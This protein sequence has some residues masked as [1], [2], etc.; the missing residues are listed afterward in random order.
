VR[1]DVAED[2]GSPQ[3]HVQFSRGPES[4]LESSSHPLST[5]D[6]LDTN[7]D[8]P[9]RINCPHKRLP[10][11]SPIPIVVLGATDSLR[12]PSGKSYR[13]STRPALMSVALHAVVLLLC[14]PLTFATLT[15][16]SFSLLASPP[17]KFDDTTTELTEIEIEATPANDLEL[18]NVLPDQA[19]FN[20]TNSLLDDVTPMDAVAASYEA[21]KF[22][23]ADL[24]PSDLGTLMAGAGEP[25]GGQA[26]GPPGS[27]VFFGARSLGDRF[28]FIVDNSSSMK[29]GRLEGAIGE[30][31]NSVAAMSRRQWFYVIFVS[32]QPYPM[33]YP[34]AA[35]ALLPATDENKKRLGE[36]LTK[37]RLASGKNREIIKAMDL[38]ASLEPHAVFLLWDGDMRYSADVRRD[39]LTHLTRPNEWRFT[40]HTLGMGIESL[41]S[42]HDLRA[43]ASAHGGT[44]QRV[45][46]PPQKPR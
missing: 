18:Q 23:Q 15:E 20:L 1:S 36:W 25:D 19:A 8:Q 21:A 41:D 46:L 16:N 14:L 45:D 31:V 30:L 39:V 12:R 2:G 6:R 11:E 29:N 3:P 13:R 26:G 32:D 34:E 7:R 42:E 35:P 27:A 22:G 5:L 4:P 24:M 44:F 40:I 10:D 9:I 43:I 38:A 17:E 28:V 33:F 37:V